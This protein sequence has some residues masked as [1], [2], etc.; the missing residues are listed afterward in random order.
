MSETS[1]MIINSITKGVSF[2]CASQGDAIGCTATLDDLP[3]PILLSCTAG[4]CTDQGEV[5]SLDES[6]YNW[7]IVA[8]YCLIATLIASALISIDS[9]IHPFWQRR[10]RR[11]SVTFPPELST[12]GIALSL[13]FSD[14][15][16]VRD[17][18]QVLNKICGAIEAPAPG[19]GR[20]VAVTG[21]SGA[22]K[23]TL[24]E[25]I[26]GR[27]TNG[28]TGSVTLNGKELTANQ[29]R[30]QFA[31][32][33]QDSILAA[34]LTVSEVLE[35]AAAMRLAGLTA[36]QRAG[37]VRWLLVTLGLEA[38]A[39]SKIGDSAVR[40]ISGGERRRVDIGVELI[41][42]PEVLILDEPTTGLDAAA[43][44]RLGEVLA[45]LAKAGR[46][47]LCSLHQPR[48]ELI[49]LFHEHIDLSVGG[50]ISSCS[51]E[52]YHDDRNWSQTAPLVDPSDEKA[53]RTKVSLACG[54]HFCNSESIRQASL[55]MQVVYLWRRTFLE[56][57]RGCREQ[58][59]S[60]LV[61]IAIALFVGIS[62]QN[63]TPGIAGVQNRFGSIFFVQL[64]FSF[65][66]L[67]ACTS[68]FL[69]RPRFDRERTSEMYSAFAYFWSKALAYLWWYCFLLPLLFVAVSYG[70][71]GY[72]SDGFARQLTFFL[73]VAGTVTSASGICLF[74]LS[75]TSS[76]AA[77]MST[78]AISLTVLLMY[79]GFLQRPDAIP[80]AL[81]W[82]VSVSPFSH[83]FQAMLTNELSGLTTIVDAEGFANVAIQGDIWL[84]QFNIEPEL[85]NIHAYVLA[86]WAAG[87]WLLAFVPF[88]SWMV[89]KSCRPSLSSKN[90]TNDSQG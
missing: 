1:R 76:F 65:F 83:S 16:C 21:A 79:A 30:R 17:G 18:K 43:A 57:I 9:V 25:A 53:V 58:L 88:F 35:F 54:R 82:L 11:G 60:A 59:Y 20:L 2:G 33:Q 69:D 75:C 34:N 90:R 44:L 61:I 89:Q 87:S 36:Q 62:F 86:A 22:G 4:A 56:A 49:S 23:T 85:M 41:V 72:R 29:R 55:V 42:A 51:F 5:N 45:E 84:Y 52:A 63:V 19:I 14:I 64:F 31:F 77:G 80:L 26:A 48:P 71:V 73:C 7:T 10:L 38:I 39:D 27:V 46:L 68:W 13:R 8:L 74:C 32:V 24:L 28:D 67:K 50:H 81:R 70:L 40:G 12:K 47:V 37:R 66:G 6:S 3:L 78:S 15:S